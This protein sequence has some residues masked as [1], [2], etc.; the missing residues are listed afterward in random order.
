M[1]R[2]ADRRLQELERRAE[3]LCWQASR[4]RL[5]E[6]DIAVLASFGERVV[7][8][9]EGAAPR[10]R[11]TPEEQ[12]ALERW[13]AGYERARLEGWGGADPPPG[14]GRDGFA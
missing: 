4:M 13:V 2:L 14:L 5:G 11:P 12:R 9:A 3:R 8:H 7:A 6:E 1:G 10:P